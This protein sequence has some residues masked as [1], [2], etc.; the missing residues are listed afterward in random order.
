MEKSL[1]CFAEAVQSAEALGELES[2]ASR[3]L[4]DLGF[5]S[6]MLSHHAAHGIRELFGPCNRYFMHR[7]R[8]ERM[9][10][11]DPVARAVDTSWLPVAWDFRDY[12]RSDERRC[13]EL[14]EQSA[15]VGYERGISAPINGPHGRHMVL[16]GIYG[17]GSASLRASE[18]RLGHMLMILGV[19]VARAHHRL[20]ARLACL[21]P[22]LTARER[23][24]LTWSSKGKTAWEVSRIIGVAERTVNFHLQ[25]AMAK[26]EAPSKHQAYLRAADLNLI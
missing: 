13:A 24:C 23:E 15:E 12:V 21:G 10:L 1:D 11:V 4:A 20:T 17:G 26:L 25:N 8:T 18:R 2:L 7:Y 5:N 22:A 14:F 9:D 6:F 16:A 19:H 3:A